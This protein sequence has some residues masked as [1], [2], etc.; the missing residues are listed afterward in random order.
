MQVIGLRLHAATPIGLL[1]LFGT[2]YP[3]GGAHAAEASRQQPSPLDAFAQAKARSL[4]PPDPA[5]GL[6][7]LRR[8]QRRH[9]QA[10]PSFL[11]LQGLTGHI[12]STTG[13]QLIQQQSDVFRRRII[14]PGLL[15][16]ERL[17]SRS[18]HRF[19]GRVMV[20]AEAELHKVGAVELSVTQADT[21]CSGGEQ[22]WRSESIGQD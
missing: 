3:P 5:Q 15:N 1:H 9:R 7:Q 12:K 4:H 22:R 21:H 6:R 16:D 20:M 10:G 19:R 18:Q 11:H 17:P 14:N 2:Q 8:H 13:T